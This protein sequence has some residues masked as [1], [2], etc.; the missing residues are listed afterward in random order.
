MKEKGPRKCGIGKS[1]QQSLLRSVFARLFTVLR[2]R[3]EVVLDSLVNPRPQQLPWLQ[4]PPAAYAATTA[5]YDPFLA[6]VK[7]AFRTQSLAVVLSRPKTLALPAP[8]GAISTTEPSPTNS[9]APNRKRGSSLQA[10]A[11]QSR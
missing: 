8:P 10:L 1:Q 11:S 6:G 3:P 5:R 7:A 2:V 4:S 9:S